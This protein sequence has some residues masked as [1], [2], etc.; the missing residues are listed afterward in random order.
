MNLKTAQLITIVMLLIALLPMPYGYYTLVRICVC[1][2]SSFLAYKTWQ[3]KINLWMWIFIIIAI[4]FNP[5]IPIYLSRELWAVIDI[6]VAIV[7]FVSISQ[8][9]IDDR[10]ET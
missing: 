4:L 7:F 1:V 10:Q 2:L 9:K 8:L 5:I 6:V 3:E